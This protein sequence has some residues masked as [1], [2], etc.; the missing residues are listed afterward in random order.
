[1]RVDPWLLFVGVSQVVWLMLETDKGT[2]PR[3]R[4]MISVGDPT[5]PRVPD[6]CATE[7]IREEEPRPQR[8][9]RQSLGTRNQA[10]PDEAKPG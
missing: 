9:P 5:L 4:S 1:M 3:W 2:P 8:V 10:P 6:E 7:G